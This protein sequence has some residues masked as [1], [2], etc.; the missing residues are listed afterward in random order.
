MSDERDGMSSAG[1]GGVPLTNARAAE[2]WAVPEPLQHHPVEAALSP[3]EE[4][5]VQWEMDQL[6]RVV[7]LHLARRPDSHDWTDAALLGALTRELRVGPQRPDDLSPERVKAIRERVLLRV[8]EKRAGLRSVAGRPAMRPATVPAPP[9]IAMKEAGLE[10]CA[11][12][13]DPAVAAGPGREIWDGECDQ[14]VEYPPDTPPGDYLTMTIEGDSMLPLL[15]AGDAILVKVSEQA[16]AGTIVVARDPDDRYV[17][18]R[19]GRLSAAAIELVS[20]NPA[21]RAVRVARSRGTIVGTVVLRWCAHA[22]GAAP[23]G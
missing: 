23:H 12:H 20:E 4:E 1:D 10:Q 7:G 6:V 14:W 16:A 17:V 2:S 22:E 19:V 15:H 13:I 5:Q 18:K 9:R 11:V 3:D 21:Y 8:R